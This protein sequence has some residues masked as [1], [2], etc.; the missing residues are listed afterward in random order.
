MLAWWGFTVFLWI[1]AS[2]VFGALSGSVFAGAPPEGLDCSALLSQGYAL[3]VILQG[4]LFHFREIGF[5]PF[6]PAVPLPN[7]CFMQAVTR[8]ATW[9]YPVFREETG[10]NIFRVSVLLV[11]SSITMMGLMVYVAP[12]LLS[13]VQTIRNL[14][15]L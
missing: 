4:D 13:G 3:Q 5:L 6:N 15:R 12:V 8:L 1:G 14:F 10:L 11:F 2:L 9:S 7:V